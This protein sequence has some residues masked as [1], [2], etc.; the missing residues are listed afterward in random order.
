MAGLC[1]GDPVLGYKCVRGTLYEANPASGTMTAKGP[2]K[3]QKEVMT[4]KTTVRMPNN[5]G[6]GVCYCGEYGGGVH[7]KSARCE[8]DPVPNTQSP[9]PPDALELPEGVKPLVLTTNV[10]GHQRLPLNPKQEA[11]IQRVRDLGLEFVALLHEA[12]GTD[13]NQERFANRRLAVAATE[14]ETVVMWALKG[15]CNRD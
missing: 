5:S 3:C 14:M 1:I 12:G 8:K 7:T 2:C 9:P 10:M 4:G 11:M 13:P 15:I 6:P